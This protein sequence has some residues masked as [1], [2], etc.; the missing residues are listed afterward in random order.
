[1]KAGVPHDDPA[2]LPYVWR[3]KRRLPERRGMFLRV[4]TRGTLNSCMVEF[5]DGMRYVTSRNALR[6]R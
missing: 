1:M 6:R 5:D 4:I 3:W 2:D